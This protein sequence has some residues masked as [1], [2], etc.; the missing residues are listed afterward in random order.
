MPEKDGIE[1]RIQAIL[2]DRSF[3]DFSYEQR[4]MMCKYT[5]Q[6]QILTLWQAV[7]NYPDLIC[8]AYRKKI[9][10]WLRNCVSDYEKEYGAIYDKENA[11]G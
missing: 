2:A 10:A 7:N 3:N 5:L 8:A 6:Q 9:Y 11:Y 1:Q 4:K